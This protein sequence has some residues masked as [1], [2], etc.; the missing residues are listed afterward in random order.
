VGWDAELRNLLHRAVLGMLMLAAS[1]RMTR[2]ASKKA[3]R[4]AVTR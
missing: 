3:A 1:R 4:N 2:K